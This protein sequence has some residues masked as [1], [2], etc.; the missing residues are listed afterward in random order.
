MLTDIHSAKP[1]HNHI[2][3]DTNGSCCYLTIL[4]GRGHLPMEN[5][6]RARAVPRCPKDTAPWAQP[7]THLGWLQVW[8]LQVWLLQLW[9][10]H[11]WLLQLWLQLVAAAGANLLFPNPFPIWV[12]SCSKSANVASIAELLLQKSSYLLGNADKSMV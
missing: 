6:P 1:V 4:L 12:L 7:K 11:L 5:L 3:G 2:N 8:L 9:L 10:L